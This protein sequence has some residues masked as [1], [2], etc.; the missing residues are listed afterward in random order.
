MWPDTSYCREHLLSSVFHGVTA[1]SWLGGLCNWSES[2]HCPGT[3]DFLGRVRLPQKAPS[4]RGASCMLG[5]WKSFVCYERSCLLP[6]P[7]SRTWRFQEAGQLGFLGTKNLY[8]VKWEAESFQD[9]CPTYSAKFVSGP[10]ELELKQ[11]DPGQDP[12]QFQSHRL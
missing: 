8:P 9:G 12:C 4:S 6:A 3:G 10:S 1:F 5:A 11:T 2:P 7:H